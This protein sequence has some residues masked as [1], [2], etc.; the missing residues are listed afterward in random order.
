MYKK[1]I[2]LFGALTLLSFGIQ[3]QN[4]GQMQ[5]SS[6]FNIILNIIELPFLFI[7]VT[8]SFLTSKKLQ[9]G[10]FGKGMKYL[11]WGFFVMALGHIHMQ[12]EHNFGVNVFNALLGDTLGK[13]IWFI[14]LIITWGFSSYGFY[15]IYKASKA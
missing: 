14:A 8:F 7:A 10:V 2:L 11:A 15:S 1:S 5:D 13:A 9:G 6:S 3:A 4:S 12:L